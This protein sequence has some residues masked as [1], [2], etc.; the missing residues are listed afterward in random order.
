MIE[1]DINKIDE[2][3]KKRRFIFD[4]IKRFIDSGV[5]LGCDTDGCKFG[6]ILVL[7]GLANTGKT[8]LLRQVIC[9]YREAFECAFLEL[10][11][12]DDMDAV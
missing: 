12:D 2:S 3:G 8:T 11:A 9:E 4:E 5:I 1:I 6:K 7:K 10:E